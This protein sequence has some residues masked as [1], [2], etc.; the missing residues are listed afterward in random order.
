MIAVGL[1]RRAR[2]GGGWMSEGSRNTKTL[3]A[4]GSAVRAAVAQVNVWQSN[5]L[6]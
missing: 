6:Q 5:E 3:D 2:G 1:L 4:R